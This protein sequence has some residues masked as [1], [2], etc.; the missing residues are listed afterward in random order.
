M[1]KRFC[2]VVKV[3]FFC[4]LLSSPVVLTV[5]CTLIAIVFFRFS[6]IKTSTQ[7][8]TTDANISRQ[9]KYK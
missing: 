6:A 9:P 2:S 4:K 8:I 7:I 3:G 5:S 1:D